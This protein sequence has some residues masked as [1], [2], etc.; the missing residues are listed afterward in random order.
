MEFKDFI[1]ILC[2]IFL[3]TRYYKS[4]FVH[5]PTELEKSCMLEAIFL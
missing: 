1:R 5:N 4:R 3:F 2:L